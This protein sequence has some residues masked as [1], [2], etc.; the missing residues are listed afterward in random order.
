MKKLLILSFII[1]F[2]VCTEGGDQIEPKDVVNLLPLDDEISGW[3]RSS[4]T[5]IAENNAQLWDLI[6]GEGQIYIDNGFVKCAFQTY[7]GV[8]LGPVDLQLR[9]F[10]MGDTTNATNIYDELATGSEVPWTDNNAGVEARY[11]LGTG[12]VVNYYELDFWDDKFYTWIQINDGS[13][14]GLNIAKLFA[15]NVSE[16]IRDTT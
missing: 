7:T 2:F 4:A 8:I 14:A 1:L 10:D 11:K 16:A 3:A 15:L 5:Q 9:I 6:N 13:D 12:P